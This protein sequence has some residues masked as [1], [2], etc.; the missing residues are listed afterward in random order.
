MVRADTTAGPATA[1]NADWLVHWEYKYRIPAKF[2]KFAGNV[3]NGRFK[4][5]PEQ[6]SNPRDGTSACDKL[7]D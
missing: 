1:C 3:R 5:P 7:V 2:R 6:Y 4:K